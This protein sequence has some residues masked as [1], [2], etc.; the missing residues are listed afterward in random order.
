MRCH[1]T[2]WRNNGGIALVSGAGTELPK[3]G[4]LIEEDT[5]V[6]A[7]RKLNYAFSARRLFRSPQNEPAFWKLILQK[8]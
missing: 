1:R 2:K 6:Q 7:G 5:D 3:I 8:H 4:P